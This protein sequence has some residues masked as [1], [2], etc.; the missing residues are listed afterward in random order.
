LLVALAGFART[1]RLPL[2]RL[3]VPSPLAAEGGGGPGWG[4]GGERPAGGLGGGGGGGGDE[5]PGAV[6]GAADPAAG[7]SGGVR[8]DV[9]DI[10]R[11]AGGDADRAGRQR[12]ARPRDGGR[13]RR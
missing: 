7:D 9:D 1:R 5:R 12:V 11:H 13:R 10:A 3:L 6:P 4:G 2:E 8:L